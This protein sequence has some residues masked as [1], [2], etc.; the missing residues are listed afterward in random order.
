MSPMARRSDSKSKPAPKAQA[1]RTMPS[2]FPPVARNLAETAG[3]LLRPSDRQPYWLGSQPI[4]NLEDLTNNLE[5]FSDEHA[6]WVADWIE[7]LGDRDTAERIRAE[8]QKFK[9]IVKHRYQ[10]LKQFLGRA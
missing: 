7:Y 6:F 1:E 10:E 2:L 4:G 8:Q 9:E 5:K 3:K